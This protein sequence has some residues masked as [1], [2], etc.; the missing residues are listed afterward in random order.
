MYILLLPMRTRMSC[1]HKLITRNVGCCIDR[2]KGHVSLH[3]FLSNDNFDGGSSTIVEHMIAQSFVVT[4]TFCC[5]LNTHNRTLRRCC[6]SDHP[7]S[8]WYS[9]DP[10]CRRLCGA[11]MHRPYFLW[12][13]RIY[14]FLIDDLVFK[15]A[16]PTQVSFNFCLQHRMTINNARMWVVH[17]ALIC[18]LVVWCSML[19]LMLRHGP[20]IGRFENNVIIDRWNGQNVA[21]LSNAFHLPFNN[22][23]HR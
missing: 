22:L 1:Q 20:P 9:E 10:R 13:R 21:N 14:M 2:A 6:W 7:I 11:G 12:S 5:I 18:T 19:R 17:G 15:W 8:T 4:S 23:A 16:R 3:V